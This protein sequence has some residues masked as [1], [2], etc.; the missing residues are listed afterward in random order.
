M[1]PDGTA[2][3][4]GLP[5]VRVREVQ[6]ASGGP[7]VVHVM[8]DDEAAAACPVCG[9]FSTHVPQRRTTRPRDVPYGEQALVVRC[10]G[11]G[12]AAVLVDEAEPDRQRHDHTDDYRGPPLAHDI[13]G[14]GRGE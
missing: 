12:L 11:R 14:G 8:T 3:L 9:V 1:S 13:G 4:F 2:I 10:L 6:R 5:G 7:R